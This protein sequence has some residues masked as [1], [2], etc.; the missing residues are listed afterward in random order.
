MMMSWVVGYR[1][2]IPCGDIVPCGVTR[3]ER[4]ISMKQTEFLSLRSRSRLNLVCA[5]SQ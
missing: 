5:I 4:E 3:V 2:S 1:G